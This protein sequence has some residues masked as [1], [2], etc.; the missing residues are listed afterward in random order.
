MSPGTD[1]SRSCHRGRPALTRL[2]RTCAVQ[3]CRLLERMELSTCHTRVTGS[4]LVRHRRHRRHRSVAGGIVLWWLVGRSVGGP[5][6]PRRPTAAGQ[7]TVT[8][9]PPLP[10]PP[11]RRAPHPGIRRPPAGRPRPPSAVPSANGR[12]RRGRSPITGRAPDPARRAPANRTCRPRRMASLRRFCAPE[13]GAGPGRRL[14]ADYQPLAMRTASPH[15]E[16]RRREVSARFCS[17]WS[18]G[19]T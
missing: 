19:W 13:R 7:P 9:D 2:R 16:N 18:R 1:P 8:C 4:S 5:L 10:S 12:R 17:V 15:A 3:R 11:D 14:P 6:V